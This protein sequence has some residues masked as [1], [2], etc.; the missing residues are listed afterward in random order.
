MSEL[1]SVGDDCGDQLGLAEVLDLAEIHQMCGPS[2][3]A[4]AARSADELDHGDEYDFEPSARS[5]AQAILAG[6]QAEVDE[7][8]DNVPPDVWA[9]WEREADEEADDSFVGAFKT[10]RTGGHGG[11]SP[12]SSSSTPASP[13]S[14]MDFVS[15]SFDWLDRMVSHDDDPRSRIVKDSTGRRLGQLKPMMTDTGFRTIAVCYCEAH[16]E[17]CS[18]SRGWREKSP[19]SPD[20]VERILVHW[21]LSADQ[22]ATAAA[23]DKAPRFLAP[24]K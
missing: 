24:K 22:Y 16:K 20:V 21:L 18:R 6:L 23:H 19:E 2:G 3:A 9:A 4:P 12:S 1:S 11:H 13:T 15:G 14:A 8:F 5:S 10:V 7:Q 17:R